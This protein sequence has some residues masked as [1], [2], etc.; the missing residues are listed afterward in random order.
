M[1]DEPLY[2]L[3]LFPQLFGVKRVPINR[4][5]LTE[6]TM[7]RLEEFLNLFPPVLLLFEP[8]H[9]VAFL[10]IL[11]SQFVRDNLSC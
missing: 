6:R 11:D 3:V 9:P 8:V 2:A 5:K 7:L 10:L 4:K 1:A